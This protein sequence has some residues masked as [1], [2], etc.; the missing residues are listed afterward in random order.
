MREL[1]ERL[2]DGEISEDVKLDFPAGASSQAAGVLD[3]LY[4]DLLAY[5][6]RHGRKI[7][8]STKRNIDRALDSMVSL[9]AQ[10]K[11]AEEG[12]YED[13]AEGTLKD[14]KR[15]WPYHADLELVATKG[16]SRRGVLVG[17]NL[18]ELKS[19]RAGMLAQIGYVTIVSSPMGKRVLLTRK[20]R[21]YLEQS[22]EAMDLI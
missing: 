6:K 8:G 18:G 7:P 5:R 9:F 1:I 13:L 2:S 15:Q 10:L 11:R 22:Q 20:G 17:D 3:R 14:F 16:Q 21:R 4:D 19:K 12:L